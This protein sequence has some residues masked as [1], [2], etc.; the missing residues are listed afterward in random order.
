MTETSVSFKKFPKITRLNKDV[1][2]TEKIDGTNATV[3]IEDFKTNQ[4]GDEVIVSSSLLSNK[5]V[6]IRA[7]SRNRWLT[8][9]DDNFGFLKWV[10]ENAEILANL[11]P[12]WHRGEWY[13]K[14]IQHG[15]GLEEKRLA[16][17]NPYEFQHKF[18]ASLK[19]AAGN[20]QLLALKALLQTVPI[21]TIGPIDTAPKF[22][23]KKLQTEGSQMVP[24]QKAEGIIVY[25][26]NS[27]TYYK[28]TFDCPTGKW[29]DK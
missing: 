24:G 12:G 19:D 5:T 22:A 23:M 10:S 18:Y 17:F 6:A 1:I 16:L 26:P 9:K 8:P 28:D 14:G 27:K 3:F 13:G 20:L 29:A 21:I 11:R 2:V 15:Y 25:N 4:D 7:G